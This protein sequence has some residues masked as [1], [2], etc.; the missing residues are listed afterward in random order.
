LRDGGRKAHVYQKLRELRDKYLDAIRKNFPKIRRLVS[1][2]NLPALLPE[3]G[4]HIA[5]AL[6]GSECTC[7]IVLEAKLRL[8]YSP[9]SRVLVVIGYADIFAAADD[10]TAPLPFD[11]IPIQP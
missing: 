3:N 2:Y 4:F 9:P 8:V 6:V 5:K 7:A 1:G 11:P 10:V